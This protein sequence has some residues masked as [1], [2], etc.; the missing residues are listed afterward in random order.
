VSLA[1]DLDNASFT[2][3]VTISAEATAAADEI[4]LNAIELDI[5]SV[6]VNGQPATFTLNVRT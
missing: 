5:H 3:S 6:S 1:P 2:G 4:V